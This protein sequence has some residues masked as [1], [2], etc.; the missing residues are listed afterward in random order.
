[1]TAKYYREK[2]GQV[3]EGCYSSYTIQHG[4]D[5]TP[6]NYR[7]SAQVTQGYSSYSVQY[8]TDV[9]AKNYRKNCMFRQLMMVIPDNGTA[10]TAIKEKTAQLTDDGYSSYSVQHGA[11][12]IAKNDRVNWSGNRLW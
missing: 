11:D 10:V 7:K 1:L 6:K 4:T 2:T 9:T 8:G 12:V 5:V 3:G